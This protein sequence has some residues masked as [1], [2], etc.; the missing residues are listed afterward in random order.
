[1]TLYQFIRLTIFGILITGCISTPPLAPSYWPELEEWNR[2]YCIQRGGEW[3]PLERK[4][5]GARP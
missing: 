4:C 5:E 1:M 3:R 2:R